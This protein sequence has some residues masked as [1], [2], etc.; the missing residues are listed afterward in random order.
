MFSK[1]VGLSSG[2][3]F[4]VNS[5]ESSVT[6]LKRKFACENEEVVYRC[7]TESSINNSSFSTMWMW[8]A[9]QVGSFTSDQT[10]GLN[11]TCNKPSNLTL[12]FI[13]T[14]LVWTSATT[15]VSLLIVSP[16][17][18]QNISSY[19][20]VAN[21][22]QVQCTALQSQRQDVDSPPMMMKIHNISSKYIYVHCI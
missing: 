11:N 22:K 18:A 14:T 21:K 17:L 7:E 2:Y 1:A 3:N 13:H 15:C 10:I 4:T 20:E 6:V 9:S 19:R 5:L 12:C 8:D 16:S